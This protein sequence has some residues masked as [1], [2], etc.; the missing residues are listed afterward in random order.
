MPNYRLRGE[1]YRVLQSV[2]HM[3]LTGSQI[4]EQCNPRSTARAVY[5]CIR[6]LPDICQGDIETIS[7]GFP[8]PNRYRMAYD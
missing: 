8:T 6:K 3:Y 4:A 2:D 5:D 7:V 1:I